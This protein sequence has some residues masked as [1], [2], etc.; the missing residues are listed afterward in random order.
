MITK[1]WFVAGIGRRA[2]GFRHQASNVKLF[3]ADLTSFFS[4]SFFLFT[5]YFI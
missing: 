5:S 2:S 3:A 4:F 1:N